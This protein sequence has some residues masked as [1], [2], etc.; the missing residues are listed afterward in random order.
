[1]YEH[2]GTIGYFTAVGRKSRKDRRYT[3]IVMAQEKRQSK[4]EGSQAKKERMV[5][6]HSRGGG[7]THIK[8]KGHQEEK[9]SLGRSSCGNP[10]KD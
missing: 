6:R 4:E 1:M 5:S 2:R 7:A 8:G 3:I 9:G 10:D